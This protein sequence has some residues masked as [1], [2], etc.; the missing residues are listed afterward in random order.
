[1]DSHY[2]FINNCINVNSSAHDG[3]KNGAKNAIRMVQLLYNARSKTD[4]DVTEKK[5]LVEKLIGLL[6]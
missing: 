3:A 5:K 4:E 6:I 1:M 2:I